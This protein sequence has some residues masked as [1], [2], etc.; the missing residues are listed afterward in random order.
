MK[1]LTTVITGA[2]DG[3]IPSE[4]SKHKVW[5]LMDFHFAHN[6]AEMSGY[7]MKNVTDAYSTLL[8]AVDESCERYKI[9]TSEVHVS[10][11]FSP[12]DGK[13]PKKEKP[14]GDVTTGGK[15]GNNAGT[16]PTAPTG[17]APAEGAEAHVT[18]SKGKGGKKG[19]GKSQKETPVESVHKGKQLA[20]NQHVIRKQSC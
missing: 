6:R 12:P 3:K 9:V 11:S 17:P 16:A 15:G 5:S 8:M 14:K 19:D 18:E 10:E 13:K 2:G 4:P 1:N 7:T 20:S